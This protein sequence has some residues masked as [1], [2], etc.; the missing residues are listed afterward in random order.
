M[1]TP[2][3]RAARRA[4]ILAS[5]DDRLARLK[6]EPTPAKPTPL[7]ESV[8]AP[9]PDAADNT[10]GALSSSVLDAVFAEMMRDGSATSSAAPAAS[11]ATRATEQHT[12]PLL[13][14]TS[15]VNTSSRVSDAD[16]AVDAAVSAASADGLRRRGGGTSGGSSAS[17]TTTAAAAA[18]TGTADTLPLLRRVTAAEDGDPVPATPVKTPTTTPAPAVVPAPAPAPAPVPTAAPA[19]APAPS[20]T[21]STTSSTSSVPASER[22]GAWVP[23]TTGA[24]AAAAAT[25]SSALTKRATRL[26]WAD[27]IRKLRNILLVLLPAALAVVF[28]WSWRACSMLRPAASLL[29]GD[30]GSG[31]DASAAAASEAERLRMAALLGDAFG[32]VT[33]P[34]VSEEEEVAAGKDRL[35]SLY[36]DAADSSAWTSGGGT[37]AFAQAVCGLTTARLPLPSVLL[38]LIALRYVVNKAL[39]VAEESLKASADVSKPAAAAAVAAAPAVSSQPPLLRRAPSSAVEAWDAAPPPS[40]AGTEDDGILTP[41]AGFDPMAQLRMLAQ[42]RAGAAGGAAGADPL[43]AAM[44]MLSGGQ[45]GGVAGGGLAA[46]ACGGGGGGGGLPGVLKH[47]PKVLS[48]MGILRTAAADVSAFVFAAV[49]AA[50]LVQQL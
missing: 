15:H 21:S 33:A 8:P 46:A 40:D 50:S 10:N 14:A 32:G 19:P 13:A 39:T 45:P 41:G 6:G 35:D 48:V 12:A 37:G 38:L 44:S 11:A 24:A 4:R 17:A 9:A 20:T 16:A 36:G 34:L 43:L 25:T 23:P 49:V 2:D 47:V 1:S 5:K 30:G 31:G 22:K 28:V 42:Q 3:E 29:G 27:R 7:A 26:R 18:T